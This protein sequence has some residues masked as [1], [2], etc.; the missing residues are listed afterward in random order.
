M[1]D[2]KRALLGDYA[3]AKRLTDAGIMIPCPLCGRMINRQEEEA[4][5]ML[6]ETD[7]RNWSYHHFC[8]FDSLP[9]GITVYGTSK[10]EVISKWN[11]RTP[12]LSVGEMEELE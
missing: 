12:I 2:V 9:S 5:Y 3:A 7:V 1:E 10:E 4:T 6:M 8:R 11:T